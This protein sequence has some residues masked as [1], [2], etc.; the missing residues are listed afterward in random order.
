MTMKDIETLIGDLQ[1][2]Y[3]LLTYDKEQES[4]ETTK[5]AN[6]LAMVIALLKEQKAIEPIYN[7]EKYEDYLPHC[8]NCEKMLP[9]RTVY[10][11]VNFCY[12]CRKAVKWSE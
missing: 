4:A 10:G 6:D 11:K 1:E 3:D 2:D 7:K 9:N 5:I 8:G 12:Y